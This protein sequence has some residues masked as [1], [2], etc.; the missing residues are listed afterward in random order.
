MPASRGPV[1]FTAHGQ[2]GV[3]DFLGAEAATGEGE[4]ISNQW[5][6]NQCWRLPQPTDH[7]LLITDYLKFGHVSFA[8]EPVY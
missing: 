1:E 7:C 3:A 6:S 4:V 2:D 8:P 5:V